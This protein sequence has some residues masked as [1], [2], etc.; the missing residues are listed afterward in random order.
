[1][2]I[3]FNQKS[4]HKPFS[5]AVEEVFKDTFKD[6][7]GDLRE[8]IALLVKLLALWE[9]QLVRCYQLCEKIRATEDMKFEAPRTLRIEAK[10]VLV[11]PLFFQSKISSLQQLFST[12]ERQSQAGRSVNLQRIVPACHC[13]TIDEND[14]EF[15]PEHQ[16]NACIRFR[17]G[18]FTEEEEENMEKIV[19]YETNRV[20]Y[21]T[22]SALYEDEYLG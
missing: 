1:M 18:P 11:H 3:A 15:I 6:I 2:K 7:S 13:V 10:R 12:P 8:Q 21:V 9:K 14:D 22:I 4:A 5:A 20:A 17:A 19:K 16:T